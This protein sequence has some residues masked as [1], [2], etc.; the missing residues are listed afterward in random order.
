MLL[1]IGSTTVPPS[2]A[3]MKRNQTPAFVFV[4]GFAAVFIPLST[5]DEGSLFSS[6]VLWKFAAR[7]RASAASQLESSLRAFV[8]PEPPCF[9]AAGKSWETGN[10]NWF[11]AR[12]CEA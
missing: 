8:T 3:R 1:K 9:S 5:E 6:N 12:R 2:S 7:L 10:G 11:V 4:G